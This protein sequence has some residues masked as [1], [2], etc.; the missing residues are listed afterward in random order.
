MMIPS[1]WNASIHVTQI[2]TVYLPSVSQNQHTS[3]NIFRIKR[4]KLVLSHQ[5]LKEKRLKSFINRTKYVEILFNYRYI[6]IEIKYFYENKIN[7]KV[8]NFF[9]TFT[10]T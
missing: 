9:I 3:D 10:K 8:Y 7:F 1:F 6:Q 4:F 5:I 2:M